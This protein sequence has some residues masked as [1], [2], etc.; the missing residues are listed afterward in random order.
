MNDSPP[1]LASTQQTASNLFVLV[2]RLMVGAANAFE[3]P[4]TFTSIWEEQV[5]YCRY[6][7]LRAIAF[8]EKLAGCSVRYTCLWDG[9]HSLST[10][11]CML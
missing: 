11:L 3:D 5:L 1:S 6:P 2:H 9:S 8:L 4:S 10:L 7:S